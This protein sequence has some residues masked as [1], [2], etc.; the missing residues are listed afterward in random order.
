MDATTTVYIGQVMETGGQM[1]EGIY[2]VVIMFLMVAFS[3]LIFSFGWKSILN[4]I[5]G[6]GR[7]VRKGKF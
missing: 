5:K 7:I 4:G 6:A 1:F 2:P 3:I